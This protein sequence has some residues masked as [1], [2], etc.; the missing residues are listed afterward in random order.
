MAGG[1][2]PILVSGKSKSRE[3]GCET[4]DADVFGDGA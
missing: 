1:K 4:I 3:E 2:T